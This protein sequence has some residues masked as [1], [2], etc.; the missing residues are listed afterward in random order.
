MVSLVE[1]QYKTNICRD[2]A[3]YFSISLQGKYGN[4]GRHDMKRQKFFPEKKNLES[5]SLHNLSVILFYRFGAIAVYS[6]IYVCVLYCLYIFIFIYI[7]IYILY[8][9]YALYTYIYSDYTVPFTSSKLFW[10]FFGLGDQGKLDSQCP[11]RW[12]PSPYMGL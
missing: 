1:N 4:H 6:F 2:Y 5:L 3:M 10:R 7:Y 8:F 12:A 9:T 11:T